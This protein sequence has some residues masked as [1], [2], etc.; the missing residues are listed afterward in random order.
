MDTTKYTASV[1]TTAE[2][3]AAGEYVLEVGSWSSQSTFKSGKP[4]HEGGWWMS[5]WKRDS[6]GAWKTYREVANSAPIK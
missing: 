5:L 2:L 4:T 3:I 1:D 6:T